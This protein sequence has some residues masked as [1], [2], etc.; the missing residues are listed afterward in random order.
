MKPM[1]NALKEKI[2]IWVKNRKDIS[3]LIKD[4]NIKGMDLS[5]AIIKELD[6]HDQDIRKTNFARAIIGTKDNI[7]NMNR[8]NLRGCCFV[9]TQF[10]G[11]LWVR[12]ADIRDCN[13]KGAYVPFADYK[14][15]RLEGCNFC[16]TVF[17]IGTQRAYGASFSPD[18]FKDL[19]KF[20]GIN[21][22][23]TSMEE[24]NDKN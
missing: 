10:P 11:K 3:D 22:T 23:V 12:R 15:A 4:V 17:S 16:D 5:G 2:M 1:T 13:F 19:A 21:V 18:F 24:K 14:F 9:R 8:T 20:W 6:I 7:I